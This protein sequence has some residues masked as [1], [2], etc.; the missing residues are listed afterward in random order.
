VVFLYVG[1]RPGEP[2]IGSHLASVDWLPATAADVNYYKRGGFRWIKN[3]DCIISEPEFLN[4]AQK[5]EWSLQEGETYYFYENR[6]ENGG[7][8]TVSYDKESQRLAVISS[9]K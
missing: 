4:L 2:E 9:Y 8:V 3:Y 6:H 1:F 7:G 5:E